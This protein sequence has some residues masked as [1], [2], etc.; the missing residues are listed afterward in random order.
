M[1]KPIIIFSRS[2]DYH[3]AAVKWAVEQRGGEAILWDGL[4]EDDSGKISSR[5]GT[6]SAM[7]NLGGRHD[8]AFSSAW[9]RRRSPYR[10]LQNA[11]PD[12][13]TF[14]KNEMSAVHDAL[15]I[16]VEHRSDYVVGGQLS[17]RAS[18]KLLQLEA[19]KA[20]GL[21]VPETLISNDYDQ[22][23][24]F[25]SGRP[26]VLVKHFLPHYWGDTS[27]GRV[28]GVGPRVI[29]DVSKLN[30]RSIEICPAIYQ[31]LVDKVYEIRVTVIGERIFA[32]KIESIKGEA[33]LDWRQ[34]YSNSDMAM[35]AM[36]LDAA[37]EHSVRGFMEMLDLRYGCL[38][39]AVD[40]SG[41]AV[42][43]EVNPGGQFLFV[44]EYVPEFHLL[45]AFASMLTAA[46]PRYGLGPS[47]SVTDAAFMESE[48]F[49]S[50]DARRK[51]SRDEER[52]FTFV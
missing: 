35:S 3:A 25:A 11:H 40:R 44:E 12:S 36:T 28:S 51:P 5:L 13:L 48:E 34:E 1:L 7:L 46:S 6:S 21:S 2:D 10:S 33:F 19:A 30:R 29:S 50:W 9:F 42:F 52:F 32:A 23:S 16:S 18:S 43:L 45:D 14:L 4:D 20:V 17:R 47:D 8:E 22:L 27:S 37:T 31:D 39:F 41:R 26:C 24:R 15:C 38:D 49:R